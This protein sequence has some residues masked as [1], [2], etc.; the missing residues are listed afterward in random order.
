MGRPNDPLYDLQAHLPRLGVLE[1]IWDDHTGRGVRVGIYSNGVDATNPDIAPNYDAGLH[2]RRAGTTWDASPLQDVFAGTAMAGLVGMA[3][4]NG[5]GGTGVAPDASLTGVDFLNRLQAQAQSLP[6]ADGLAFLQ[7]AIRWGTNFD[8][9]LN[10][11]GLEPRFAREQSLAEPRSISERVVYNNS[12]Q[13]LVE[14]G[15]DGK[16]TVIV[17]SPGTEAANANGDG[18]SASR[19]TITTAAYEDRGFHDSA[20]PYGANIL[21]SAPL[22][23]VTADLSGGAGL[24]RQG[25]IQGDLDDTDFTANFGAF[26]TVASIPNVAGV[27]ALM[28]EANPDLGWRDV[29]TILAA[30]AREPFEPYVDYVPTGNRDGWAE[31]GGVHWNGGGALFSPSY[32]FGRLDAFGAVRMAEV[33]TTLTGRSATSANERSAGAAD[34][35]QRVVPLAQQ[36]QQGNLVPGAVFV[37]FEISANIRVEHAALTV[38][39]SAANLSDVEIYLVSPEGALTT[40]LIHRGFRSDVPWDDDAATARWRWTFG[41][42]SFRGVE[43]SGTWGVLVRNAG[44]LPD[45]EY[46]VLNSV[47]LDLYGAQ[48]TRNDIYTYTDDFPT[49]LALQPERGR[50]QDTDGGTDWINMAAVSGDVTADLGSNGRV[51]VDGEEWFRLARG[52]P[53]IENIVTGDG[54]DRVTGNALGNHIIGGRGNDRIEGLA[55]DDTLD[56]GPGN[57][58]LL[59]GRGNDLL[60]GGPGRDRLN[61]G[62][63]NDT[64]DGGAGNDTLKGGAGRDL[65]LGGDG[66]DLLVGGAGNDTLNGGR[67]DDTLNGGAGRDLL[68]G[69]PGDDLLRGGAGDDT[70][71]G[72]AGRD[73]LEGGA[74]AD[75]LTGGA[76][77]DVFVFARL[78]HIGRGSDSDRITDFEVGRDRI[79]LRGLDLSF[80]GRNFS[81]EAGSVRFRS[82]GQDGRLEIDAGGNGRANAVLILE[83][84]TS[85]D[86]GDLWL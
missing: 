30:S 14:T 41:D 55:G 13:H 56:G 69:G 17:H 78:A 47:R 3:A 23:T 43:A 74:G 77:A 9:V 61:G 27:V 2:F 51:R 33:W 32:G 39:L 5:I 65:L 28:L 86:P 68:I 18:L 38:D 21:V 1:S 71:E 15:R 67:G 8:V 57:D 49:L 70:L 42:E 59:G 82:D 53:A 40:Q 7:A 81:G 25:P 58:T 48:G 4:N 16:G 52:E 64:L 31:K 35:T 50:L 10:G 79:D 80:D 72:G 60:L 66:D 75:V 26:G 85:F 11:W 54:N 22:G 20:S 44:L 76:G 45:F 6:P 84:V 19:F 29:K 83:G 37:P 62:A 12:F 63:G 24:N 34:S 73:T 36:D 46:V